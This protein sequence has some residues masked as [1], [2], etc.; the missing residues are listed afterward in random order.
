MTNIGYDESGQRP[1]ICV[2]VYSDVPNDTEK[3]KKL[4]PKIRTHEF[5]EDRLSS[6]KYNFL[7]YNHEDHKKLES[8]F[9]KKLGIVIGSLIYGGRIEDYLRIFVDG[10]VRN[11]QKDFTLGILSDITHLPKSYIEII[12]GP[13]LDRIYKIVNI[14]DETAHWFLER[15][16]NREDIKQDIHVKP[17]LLEEL[18]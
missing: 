3:E 6:M 16:R 13:N 7:L 9:Y 15:T 11:Q 17:L 14:A 5:T 10:D 8:N 12:S 2:A 1:E 18:S 4:L